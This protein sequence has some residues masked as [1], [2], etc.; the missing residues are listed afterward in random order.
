MNVLLVQPPNHYHGKN[1]EQVFFPTGMGYIARAIIDEG[2]EVEVLD[3]HESQISF[4][5]ITGIIR[6]KSFDIVGISA[7]S[8]HY[9][10]VRRLAEAVKKVS[11]DTLIILGWVLST[12]S[13]HVVLE[14]TEVDICVI[15]E[16]EITIKEL[17]RSF[18]N[19]DAIDGIAFKKD[20][21]IVKNNDRKYVKN[22][23]TLP[24]PAYHLFPM[25]EYITNLNVI[26][27]DKAV[28]TMNVPTG[29]G[30]PYNC[31]FCSK[32]FS[33]TRVRSISDVIK[34]IQ[35]LKD[36]YQIEGVIFADE[37]LV[38]RRSRVLELCD[39]I[40]ELE[41][42]WHCQGRVNLVDEEVLLSMK[43]AGCKAIGYGF[44]SGSQKILDAMNKK[45]TISQAKKAIFETERAG[46][47]PIFQMMFGYPG[48]DKETIRETID[49]FKDIGHPGCDFSPTTPLP[50]TE[51]WRY[52]LER[53]LIRNEKDFLEKLEGGYS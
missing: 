43:S 21:R 16:G 17:L 4:E 44:E 47:Y 50:G 2:H 26:G 32:S 34:E 36:N 9:N 6:Q 7:M 39:R 20:G 23:D 18:G 42:N 30:C 12:H 25:E 53:G 51:L 38:T 28:R 3:V 11:S 10:Y 8:T 45:A 33:G 27:S 1:R 52:S 29:R 40:R 37:C 19:Y 22:L 46:L 35:Y 15:G 49:F 31:N 14:N 13:Y 24:W 41:L 5:Q 48:E